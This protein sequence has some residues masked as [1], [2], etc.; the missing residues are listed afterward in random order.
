MNKIHVLSSHIANQIAAGEVVE[1]PTAIVKELVENS[2]D[3]EADHIIV[4]YQKGGKTVISVE[5]NGTGMGAED[6]QLAFQRHA[7]S[8]LSHIQDLQQIQSFGFRGEALPSI[9][10]VSK[11]LLQT[12]NHEDPHGIEILYHNGTCLHAKACSQT[13]G[14]RI[15]VTDLFSNMPARRRF[16]KSETTESWHIQQTLLAIA[17]VQQQ[18]HFEVF[19]GQRRLFISP[20]QV[21][22]TQRCADLFESGFAEELFD[23]SDKEGDISIQGALLK[24]GNSHF[25]HKTIWTF[26]NKRWIT[27]RFLQSILSEA[28]HEQ[29]PIGRN[30]VAFLNI[31]IDPSLID[32]NVHPQK[33]EIRFRNER[34]LRQILKI[35]LERALPKHPFVNGNNF[36]PTKSFDGLRHNPSHNS[37]E[38]SVI[39]PCHPTTLSN[40]SYFPSSHYQCDAHDSLSRQVLELREPQI[41]FQVT[42]TYAR[43]SELKCPH[44]SSVEGEKENVPLHWKFIGTLRSTYALFE[45]STGL[46]VLHY[47]AAQERILY[48]TLLRKE[49]YL[50]SVQELLISITLPTTGDKDVTDRCVRFLQEYGWKCHIDSQKQ[51]I[52]T[53]I[54]SWLDADKATLYM[55]CLWSLE[56]TH[57]P[58]IYEYT[59]CKYYPYTSLSE[60]DLPQIEKTVT[61]LF[62]CQQPLMTA[63]GQPIYYEIPFQDIE[64]R[65]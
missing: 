46:I 33:K 4:H 3:A 26:V 1:R 20:A 10:S 65:F 61:A 34:P 16:L 50:E 2:L 5:D 55:Q 54:P 31:T 62:S 27:N 53:A 48:E 15:T 56:D 12:K 44:D 38:K 24:P 41:P 30:L 9:A 18:V 23:V 11:V 63:E 36:F 58:K 21:S 42:T 7:T 37:A 45:S 59:L 35:M 25:H 28:Y 57:H 8:K 64:K 17:L 22:W 47:R 51:C 14:T 43:Q 39:A 13:K 52:I 49:E 6:A 60:S 32:I 29:L 40:I 19:D